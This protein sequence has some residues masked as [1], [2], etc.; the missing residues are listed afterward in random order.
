MCTVHPYVDRLT[1]WNRRTWRLH[2]QSC[3]MWISNKS[4]WISVEL[5]YHYLLNLSKKKKWLIW[6]ICELSY[7]QWMNHF[8]LHADFVAR[9]NQRLLSI[10]SAQRSH[11][12]R[13]APN[14]NKYLCWQLIVTVNPTI[15]LAVAVVGV[16]Q[17]KLVINVLVT[18]HNGYRVQQQINVIQ[19]LNISK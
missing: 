2:V 14:A 6:H 1:N 11:A 15:V 17:R 4:P 7:I 12:R 9:S 18:S 19:F 13:K 3:S 16:A 5:C 10:F 8:L